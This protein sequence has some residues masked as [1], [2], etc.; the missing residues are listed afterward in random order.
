MYSA[1]TTWAEGR[2]RGAAQRAR[3]WRRSVAGACLSR[4]RAERVQFWLCVIKA[5]GWCEGYARLGVRG[6][7]ATVNEMS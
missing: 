6:I 5:E 3:T 4:G 2:R 1:W 7:Q